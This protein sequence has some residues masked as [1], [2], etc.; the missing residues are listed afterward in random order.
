MKTRNLGRRTLLAGA[1]LAPALPA[2]AQTTLPDKQVQLLVGFVTGGATD[3]IARKISQPLE[4]RIG[5]HITIV[6]R[7]SGS[8]AL[9]GELL[10]KD[11]GEGRLLAFMP[12]TTLVSTLFQPSF[13][14]VAD[15]TPITIAGT[16]PIGLA[17]S[18]TLGIR[19]FDEYVK[20]AQVDDPK[21]RKLG[22]TASDGFIQIFGAVVGK[23]IGVAF[24]TQSYRSA[25]PLVNDLKDGKLLSAASGL[26]SLMEHHRS[27]RLRLLMITGPKRLANLPDVPTAGE[28][29]YPG[30]EDLEWFAFFMSSK[31]PPELITE[32]NRQIVA[33]MA[34]QGLGVELGEFGMARETS[35]PEE[36]RDRVAGHLAMWRERMI[37][38]GMKPAN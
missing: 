27:G 24:E 35:T 28:L 36:A 1:A 31:T 23:E 37:K 3:I 2:L 17:V 16:W 8:G 33:T 10:R 29:G 22:S 25:N 15:L 12:S 20:W 18:P 13:D 19:T 9:P 4:A 32:W 5:R 38:A 26:I 7:P 30:L 14:P 21:R 11:A 6:S 34:D